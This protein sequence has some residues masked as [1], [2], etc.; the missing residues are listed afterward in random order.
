[1]QVPVLSIASLWPCLS[2]IQSGVHLYPPVVEP[3]QLPP[4]GSSAPFQEL[5]GI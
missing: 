3:A 5:L 1:M 4:H 2:E